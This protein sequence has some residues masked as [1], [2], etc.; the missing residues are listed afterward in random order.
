MKRISTF[1]KYF[2]RRIVALILKLI[3]NLKITNQLL[4]MIGLDAESRFLY[5]ILSDTHS[6][7]IIQIGANDGMMCDPLYRFT[8]LQKNRSFFR[9]EPHPF[10]FKKL[11]ELHAFDA[12]VTCLQ[13]AVS[14]STDTT[15]DLF[16]IPAHV[17]DLMNG[18]AP[19][20][21][22]NWAHGQASFYREFIIDSIE[23]NKFRGTEYCSQIDFFISS[24]TSIP[25]YQIPLN[26][27][28]NLLGETQPYM[29]FLD[30]Q[31][32]EYDILST[33]NE[34]LPVFIVYEHDTEAADD[35]S[36][37]LLALGYI[38]IHTS[39]INKI[40]KLKCLK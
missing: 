22:N 5:R 15:R 40:Y 11:K 39:S 37:I 38:P 33:L 2:R 30:V 3:P 35:V 31:G 19:S 6:G 29:L 24:I 17:A 20:L 16:Y 21:Q 28:F 27:L 18:P 10:Y 8:Q 36:P 12:H 32:S 13:L 34:I 7:S 9:I 4:D 26:L 1:N 25:V 14:S 23:R